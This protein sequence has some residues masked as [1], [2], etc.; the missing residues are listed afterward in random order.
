MTELTVTKRQRTVGNFFASSF[1]NYSAVWLMIAFAVTFT[2]TAPETFPT[3]LTLKLVLTDQ[4]SIGLLA[5]A[6][7]V[8]LC[9]NTFDLSVA[10]MLAFSMVTTATLVV[11][12][13]SVVVAGAIALGSCALFGALNGLLVVRF[14]IN[15]FIAT[16]GSSQLLVALSLLVSQNA[17]VL[18]TLP[19]WFVTLS[20]GTFLGV[21]HDVYYLALVAIAVWFFL[22][23]TPTGRKLFAV[24]GNLEA[25]RIAGVPTS[26]LIFGSMVISSLIAGIAGI[27]LISKYGLYTQEFGPGYL[28]PAIAA[29]FFGATQIKGRPNVWGTLL[30]MYALAFG[31][32]GLQLTFFGN[33]YWI[34]PFFN[35]AALLIAVG[36]ASRKHLGR[37]Y[38]RMRKGTHSDSVRDQTGGELGAGSATLIPP[39]QGG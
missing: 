21:N 14:N 1:R 7:L 2:Y 18:P 30:A 34:T 11:N 19:E 22:E 10:A 13:H 25:A 26:R 29:V 20:Q 3:A 24:G 27:L 28:F 12:G 4:V 36:L 9:A 6:F 31:V 17:Q 15:S 23:H 39:S 32:A 16:L 37:E 35:G 5:L 38:K 8:P 33:E